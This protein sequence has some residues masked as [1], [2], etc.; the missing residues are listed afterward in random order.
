MPYNVG[1]NMAKTEKNKPEILTPL[2]KEVMSALFQDTWFRRHFYLTGGTGLSA[3]YLFHRYSEDLDFFS[4]G[5][6]LTAIPPLMRALSQT[7]KKPVEAMQTSPG[8]H[9]YLIDKELK[10]DVVADVSWRVGSPELIDDFMV[11][12]LKNIAVNKVGAILGRL[13]TKDYV[14]L[15]LLLTE[16]NFDIFDLLELGQNKDGGL[17]PFVW[18]SIIADVKALSLMPRMIREVTLEEL[19]TFYLKLR[20]RILDQIKPT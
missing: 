17:E 1:I 12:N 11:D 3:F 4:H 13:D 15:Y 6:E 8:F 19:K 20:D 10:I 16:Q 9:R 5:V 14:D 18:A 2:Q 7:I